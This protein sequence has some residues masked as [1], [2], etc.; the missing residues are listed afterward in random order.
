LRGVAK[1]VVKMPGAIIDDAVAP[2]ILRHVG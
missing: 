1:G 2:D